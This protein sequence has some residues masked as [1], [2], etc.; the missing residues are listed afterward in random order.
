[1]ERF[2]WAVCAMAW[3][4]AGCVLLIGTGVITL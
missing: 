1:M 2:E 3:V 4:V